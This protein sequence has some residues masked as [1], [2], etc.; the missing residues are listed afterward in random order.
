MEKAESRMASSKAESQASEV[1]VVSNPD[2]IDEQEDAELE[3]VSQLIDSFKQDVM[4]R[5][6]HA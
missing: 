3:K 6:N 1:T 4:V 2:A 5:R